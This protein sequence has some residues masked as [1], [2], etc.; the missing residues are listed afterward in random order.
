MQQQN[1]G[2]PVAAYIEKTLMEAFPD[3]TLTVRDTT[4]T[5]DHFEVEIVAAAFG[6]K[7]P[8]AQHRMVYAALGQ[9]VGREI[10][11]LALRTRAPQPQ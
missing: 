8:I 6:G 3:A 4:G 9:P 2:G 5:D 11:A 1:A 10:H 7:T